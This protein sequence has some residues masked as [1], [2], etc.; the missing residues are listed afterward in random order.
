MRV[1]INTA[2]KKTLLQITQLLFSTA[3]GLGVSFVVS[4]LNTHVLT[5]EEYGDVRYTV[6]LMTFFSTLLFLGFFV[7]G[8]RLLAISRDDQQK[9]SLRGCMLLI[10]GGVTLANMLLLTL[11]G[12]FFA[13]NAATQKVIFY[14]LTVCAAP[15]LLYY[16]NTVCQGDNQIGRIS[17]ARLLPALLYLGCGALI[18]KYYTAGSVMMLLLQNGIACAVLLL[19][20]LSTGVRFGGMKKSFRMLSEENRRYGWMVYCGSVS[21]VSLAYL[22]GVTLGFFTRDNSNVAFYTL[23]LTLAMP[24]SMLPGIIGTVMFKRFAAENSIPRKVIVASVSLTLAAWV[25]FVLLITPV[26]TFFYPPAYGAVAVWASLLSL[27]MAIHGLGDMFNRFLGAHA[28]GRALRNGAILSGVVL[29][30]GNI[31][32]VWLW[33]LRGAVITRILGSLASCGSMVYYYIKYVKSNKKTGSLE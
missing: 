33:G 9:R 32:L 7:S 4:I 25:F 18:Y 3:A 17:L 12:W 24:L 23:S 15:G 5:P 19:L 29:L 16:I 11:W 30:A 21:N 8:S 1:G 22:A 28:Q 6:N 14:S 13:P 10:L 27:G 26:V 31:L 20:V 2:V